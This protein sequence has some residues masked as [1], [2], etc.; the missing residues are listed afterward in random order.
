MKLGLGLNL[1]FR[2]ADAWYS[3]GVS[4]DS[5]LPWLIPEFMLVV[6]L[7]TEIDHLEMFCMD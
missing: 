5:L 6:V 1:N 4:V 2:I 7:R 3:R